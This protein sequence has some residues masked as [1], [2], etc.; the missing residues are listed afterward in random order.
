MN[1]EP[2]HKLTVKIGDA[3]RTVQG[4]T[5]EEFVAARDALH[6]DLAADLAVVQAA[7]A[8]VNAA[9]LVGNGTPVAAPAPVPAQGGGWDVTPPPAAPAP[10]FT[11][12]TLPSCH[13]GPMQ[14]RSGVGAKGPWRAYMCPAPK[15]TP[16]QCEPRW[17][18]KG[19][20]E[21]DTFP[22]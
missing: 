16:G 15:G 22:A 10:S 20:P 5:H 3:L 9:P 18:R 19:S 8:V 12:S 14:A 17:V 13:H 1:T 7:K 11:Q 6:A 4:Y 21:W 2:T